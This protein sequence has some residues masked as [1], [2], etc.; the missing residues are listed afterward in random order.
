MYYSTLR[1][2][3]YLHFCFSHFSVPAVIHEDFKTVYQGIHLT[4]AIGGLESLSSKFRSVKSQFCEQNKNSLTQNNGIIPPTE[5][6]A[7]VGTVVSESDADSS[8][9][10]LKEDEMPG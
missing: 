4:D 6:C 3:I 2:L 5:R 1:L 7:G 10:I 9:G 8:L